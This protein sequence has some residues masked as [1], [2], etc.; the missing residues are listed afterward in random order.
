[1]SP[2]PCLWR[3]GLRLS[4]R[5]MP[6]SSPEGLPCFPGP[7]WRRTDGTCRNPQCHLTI[8]RQHHG[9]LRRLASL[10]KLASVSCLSRRMTI[11]PGLRPT[12]HKRSAPHVPPRHPASTSSCSVTAASTNT[13][14]RPPPADCVL[15]SVNPASHFPS[16]SSRERQYL[17]PF[18]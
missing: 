3:S 9:R 4:T 12:S 7:G 16:H 11:C 17:Q 6:R 14:P 8:P 10:S 18:A 15:P 2:L 1:M 5:S 13:S